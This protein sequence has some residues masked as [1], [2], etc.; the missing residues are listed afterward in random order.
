[1]AI[2]LGFSPR[3]AR[4]IALALNP[5]T[6]L[7]SPQFHFKADEMFDMVRGKPDKDHGVWKR[8]TGFIRVSSTDKEPTAPRERQ[9][10]PQVPNALDQGV[11]DHTHLK[12][13]PAEDIFLPSDPPDDPVL[14][15]PETHTEAPAGIRRSARLATSWRPTPEYLQ[16]LAQEDLAFPACFHAALYDPFEQAETEYLHPLHL[17][18]RHDPDTFYMHQALKQPDRVHFLDAM[19][20]EVRDHTNRNHW[21]IVH[22]SKV[23]AGTKI[24]PMV[25][26]MKRKR[27]IKI[28]KVYKHK[29]HLNV[30]GGEASLW[31]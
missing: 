28:I 21:K 4:T 9:W 3:H 12:D 22:I 5:A 8:K 17:L 13:Q 27:H 29:A 20:K 25:W 7:V 16:S 11:A 30:H 24:L 1:M 26:S 18:T 23:P 10:R 15:E 6:S 14:P 31:Y 19:V 2:F